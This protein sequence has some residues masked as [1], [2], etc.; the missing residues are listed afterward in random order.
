VPFFPASQAPPSLESA[1]FPL[2]SQLAG[3]LA[4]SETSSQLTPSSSGES[5]T[6]L[7]W[8][9]HAGFD[10]MPERAMV[11]YGIDYGS[12][13]IYDGQALRM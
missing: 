2:F 5:I 13:Q 8:R 6:N 12:L 10:A 3:N 4:I 1:K 11:F 7:A 9:P